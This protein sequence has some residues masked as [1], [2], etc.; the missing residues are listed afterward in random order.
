MYD[1]P[2]G[3]YEEVASMVVTTRAW[4]GDGEGGHGGSECPSGL[5]GREGSGTGEGGRA[6]LATTTDGE[7]EEDRFQL[8]TKCIVRSAAQ[9]TRRTMGLFLSVPSGDCE[10]VESC[11]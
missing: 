2:D 11:L 8:R 1:I 5:W 3:R 7:E 10:D 4:G 6:L 9:R